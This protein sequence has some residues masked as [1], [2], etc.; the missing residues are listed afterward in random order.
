[1]E[2]DHVGFNLYR[3]TAAAGPYTQLNATLIPPQFPG[4]VWGSAYEWLDTDVQPGV[5]YYYKLADL[6]V[7]GV[8]TFHRPISIVV[9]TAPTAVK[10]QR[11]SARSA[12]MPLALGLTMMLGLVV[13]YRQMRLN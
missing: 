7:K 11:V 5:V 6:D 13:V 2:L 9:V 12:I 8:S 3:S 10:L 4:E 1:M